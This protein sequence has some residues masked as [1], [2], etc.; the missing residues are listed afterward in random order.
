MTGRKGRLVRSGEGGTGVVYEARNASGVDAGEDLIRV[1]T[2]LSQHEQAYTLPVQNMGDPPACFHSLFLSP[3]LPVSL[4]CVLL[5][6]CPIP[7]AGSTLEM[8]NVHERELFLSGKRVGRVRLHMARPGGQGAPSPEG[9][10]GRCPHLP[11]PCNGL[12]GCRPEAVAKSSGCPA[13]HY[14]CAFNTWP[15]L[16]ARSWWRSSAKRPQQASRCTPTGG[17]PT[18]AAACTSRWSCPGAPTEPSR[19][20][21]MHVL[22]AWLVSEFVSECAWSVREEAWSAV[23]GLRR[24]FHCPALLHI[25]PTHPLF[26]LL[27][28]IRAHTPRQPGARP[29]IPSGLHAS[30]R[31]AA[32]RGGCCAAAGVTGCSHSGVVAGSVNFG[33]GS[34]GCNW[35]NAAAPHTALPV[36][37]TLQPKQAAP[38]PNVGPAG[39][40]PRRPL[41]GSLQLRLVL[42]PA[43]AAGDVPSDYGGGAGAAGAAAGLPPGC[44]CGRAGDSAWVNEGY[45]SA[46]ARALTRFGGLGQSTGSMT[47]RGWGRGAIWASAHPAHALG[48]VLLPGPDGE[49]PAMSQEAFMARARALLLNVG[50]IRH[51]RGSVAG[52]GCRVCRMALVMALQSPWWAR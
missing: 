3:M 50:V 10:E 51:N 22:Q 47:W 8:I 32:L 29:P 19:C 44:A 30:G 38:G 27:A 2:A 12:P 18:S 5:P 35:T 26:L 33:V 14:R 15:H 40:P 1:L 9:Q 46:C 7:P 42:G 4:T 13:P 21:F 31:R 52:G 34:R 49:S 37:Y 25:S 16:Q 6:R 41:P 24:S 23:G 17:A 11:W 48:V 45:G 28:A 36:A 43:R 20:A 39:R